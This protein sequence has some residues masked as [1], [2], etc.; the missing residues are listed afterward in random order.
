ME[1]LHGI[2]WCSTNEVIHCQSI[3]NPWEQLQIILIFVQWSLKKIAETFINGQFTDCSLLV[4][5]FVCFWS[6]FILFY[7]L[8]LLIVFFFCQLTVRDSAHLQVYRS[9]CC[10]RPCGLIFLLLSDIQ[11][12]VHVLLAAPCEERNA[13]FSFLDQTNNSLPCF[14]SCPN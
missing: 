3:D 10:W 4:C 6:Q 14:P 5:F 13:E 11:K 1:K 8:I 9:T 12:S 2:V 7:F